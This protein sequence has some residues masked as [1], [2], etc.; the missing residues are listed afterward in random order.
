MIF[1]NQQLAVA[2]RELEKLKL[3]LD[4][5]KVQSDQ[6]NAWLIDI[7]LSA[8]SSQIAEIE[9]ELQE[10]LM[11]R[12]SGLSFSER[13]GLDDLSRILIQARIAR[14]FS[15]TEL[16]ARL[17]MKPQQVQRYEASAYM[18]AS[19][20]R[21]IEIADVLDVQVSSSFSD[22]ESSAGSL[23]AWS[24]L[25]EI[26]WMKVPSKEMVARDWFVPEMGQSMAAATEAYFVRNGGQSFASALHRKKL[27][28]Q[29]PPN[30]ITLLAWQARIL[31]LATKSVAD[32][33]LPSFDHDETWVHSLA[34]LSREADG[35]ARVQDFLHDKG[36]LLIV[37]K[38]L[39]GSYLDGAAMLTDGGHPV[40]GLTLRFDRLD[41]FWFVL[42][43]ELGHV[44]RHLFDNVH[45]DFFD[46]DGPVGDD[47]LELEADMFALDQLI[48]PEDWNSCMS[49]FALS[50]EAVR[51][52]AERLGIDESILA[53]RI[54]K[55]REDFTILGDLIGQGKV[56]RHFS[57]VFS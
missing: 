57:G 20:S 28:G 51:L 27:R 25:G 1:S 36:V 44:F 9:V 55:E 10:Y 14:G 3:A 24:D 21:L 32:K 38:H 15:Q 48:A 7:E 35:P 42:F 13:Y 45:L 46:E 2:E 5:T 52:D 23:I 49:R 22:K 41:N 29:N 4:E 37:E 31:D 8:L 40:I 19:L 53:G 43:H 50:E 54:R 18:G 16:A 30:E 39:T 6:E 34:Q 47:A 33:D 12:D 26:D 11:L 56:R 17:D